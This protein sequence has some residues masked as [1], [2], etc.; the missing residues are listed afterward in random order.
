MDIEGGDFLGYSRIQVKEAKESEDGEEGEGGR[1]VPRLGLVCSR[2]T[3]C[4]VVLSSVIFTGLG[5]ASVGQEGFVFCWCETSNQE[6]REL[7]FCGGSPPTKGEWCGRRLA[8]CRAGFSMVFLWDGTDATDATDA[9]DRAD[10]TD[11]TNGT[12]CH[13]CNRRKRIQ[14]SSGKESREAQVQ[15]RIVVIYCHDQDHVKQAP[16]AEGH[17]GAPPVQLSLVHYP[18]Q[19]PTMV[20]ASFGEVL[21]GE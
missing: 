3:V 1:Q 10:G 6:I 14:H 16:L 4:T 5:C 18:P 11:G 15:D 9:T 13:K 12:K 7:R 21:R 17:R 2:R 8:E 20:I 19:F